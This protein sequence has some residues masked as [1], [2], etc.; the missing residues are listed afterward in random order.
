MFLFLGR[1]ASGFAHSMEVPALQPARTPVTAEPP[2]FSPKLCGSPV[3]RFRNKIPI[4]LS[5]NEGCAPRK[6][7]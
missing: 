1:E 2:E 4:D 6:V 5:V 7:D 3:K